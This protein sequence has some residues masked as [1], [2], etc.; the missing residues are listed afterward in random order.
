MLSKRGKA[1]SLATSLYLL[2]FTA[3]SV[4]GEQWETSVGAGAI[5]APDYLG[6]DD[7]ETRPWPVLRLSYGDRFYFNVRDGL[8][9]NAIR[10]GSWQIS[11]FIGYTP[12]RDN[13]D[14]LERLEK[15]DGGALAGLRIA[16][17]KDAWSYSATAQTPFT[18]D[19]DGYQLALKAQWE[20]R[21]SEQWSASFG[22]K[23]TYSSED[24]TED[25]FGI[26]PGE[27]VRSGLRAYSPDGYFR[28]GLTG[29]LGYQ[30]TEQWSVAA[31]AGVSQLTGD[32]KDSPI[33]DELGDATQAYT[34][35]FTSYSF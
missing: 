5:Y 29:S 2:V 18:G 10:Q 7:Y 11:P 4:A 30:L 19:V 33:V 8:V 16:Y 14:D 9:W 3:P 31:I 17:T 35:L 1:C 24:W 23:L 28:F 25:M 21:L 34:G 20:D 26:S 13:E 12:G 6:S 27:S 15:V 32:A 22:P